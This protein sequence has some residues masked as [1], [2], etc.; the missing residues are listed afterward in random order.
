MRTGIPDGITL[1]SRKR[2]PMPFPLAHRF[3]LMTLLLTS[4]GL[5]DTSPVAAQKAKSTRCVG[6]EGCLLARTKTGWET[7]NASDPVPPDR[8]LVALFGAELKSVNGAVHASLIADI[9][10]RGPFPVLE[11]AVRIHATTKADLEI[12]LERGIT[13]FTN[14]KKNGAASLRLRVRDELFAVTLAAPKAKLA[15]EIYSR[16][17]PG[18][19][20][21]D[22]PKKDDP[23]LHAAFFALAGEASIG[24]SQQTTRLQAPPGT[25]LY[26]WDTATHTGEARRFD[27]RPDYAAPPD[28]KERERFAAICKITKGLAANPEAIN[29][30]LAN[31]LKSPD[32]LDRKTAVIALGALDLVPDLLNALNDAERP[33]VRDAAIPV[34]RQWLG[35]EQGQSIRLYDI[36]T[37]EKGLKPI[38]AKNAL[39]LLHGFEEEMLQRPATFDLLIQGLNH[40][41]LPA[42]ELARW[43]LV[44]LVPAGKLINYDA[45]ASEAQRLK[46][47]AEWRRLIPEGQLPGG[48]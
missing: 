38:Q 20:K 16:H 32:A 11:S 6:V 8:L 12:T 33:D 1:L 9:G 34:L 35:R 17:V 44:R 36:L 42:R 39:H 28:D 19:A 23:V 2:M 27:K 37:K 48:R 25:A 18:P 3:F 40:D 29:I 5:A 22:D 43:H 14:T 46:A 47:I 10:Q 30:Q 21:L 26:L 45:A 31:S 15:V 13:V 24:T 7:V 41:K 4:V